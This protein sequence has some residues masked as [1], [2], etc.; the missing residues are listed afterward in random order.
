MLLVLDASVAVK[1]FVPEPLSAEARALLPALQSGELELIAPELIV[2]EFGH[3]LRKYFFG[4][5]LQAAECPA[6]M[7]DFLALNVE[8]VALGALAED[9]MRLT[10]AHMATY[11]DAV[12]VALAQRANV[13]V[14][15][16]DAPMKGAFEKLGRVVHLA[17]FRLP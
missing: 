16:A 10:T 3:S 17:D 15:T 11:Y 1:W 14:L 7:R 4:G 13:Q 6:F 8:R 9:A 12:Y 2:A 5:Q